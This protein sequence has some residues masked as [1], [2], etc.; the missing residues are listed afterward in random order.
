M[1]Q[2]NQ[3]VSPTSRNVT[4][5]C[6]VRLPSFIIILL[7]TLRVFAAEGPPAPVR[8][9][10]RTLP[11]RLIFAA[12]I[13]YPPFS[14]VSDGEY[15]GHDIDLIRRICRELGVS[16][17]IELA[18]WPTVI[19]TLKSGSVDVVSGILKTP[20]RARIFDFTIPYLVE[21]YAL[22]T[23]ADSG[24]FDTEDLP[25][26]SGVALREDASIET[27]FEPQGLESNL[28]LTDSLPEALRKVGR[29]TYDYT[30]APYSLGMN[31]IKE[32]SIRNI[33]VTGRPV[34]SIEYRFAVQKGDHAVL[35]ALN[36]AISSLVRTKEYDTIRSRWTIYDRY[37]VPSFS[38]PYPI[39]LKLAAGIILILLSAAGAG[40]YFIMNRGNGRQRRLPNAIRQNL[41]YREV[42]EGLTVP[43][44]WRG[45]WGIDCNRACR[46]VFGSVPREVL[47]GGEKDGEEISIT[48]Q[49]GTEQRC[50]SLYTRNDGTGSNVIGVGVDITEL[51]RRERSLQS[52][53]ESLSEKN[54]E[55]KRAM[56]SDPETGLFNRRHI[57]ERID[58]EIALYERYGDPFSI[59]IIERRS[60]NHPENRQPPT[61]PDC[62]MTDLAGEVS[63]LLRS[64]DIVARYGEDAFLIL[65]PHTSR[66]E[67]EQVSRKL[68]ARLSE[69][70]HVTDR[71]SVSVSIEYREY[72]GEGRETFL[73]TIQTRHAA[74]V[75]SGRR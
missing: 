9:D 6:R 13:E 14:F 23:N 3:G 27:F 1:Y 45:P 59:V 50:L 64:V 66:S 38:N 4:V 62:V 24:I 34:I 58:T 75:S 35:F 17:E 51:K 68:E 8:S 19:D 44:F 10:G 2:H 20:E 28:T 43:I 48:P 33:V 40:L 30:V 61:P 21:A 57:I 25:E 11:E 39:D 42:I 32:Y 67:A 54:R 70:V 15:R 53:F 47:S 31:T 63:S 49:D 29:G 60:A 71:F 55:L 56:L 36:D 41:Y 46:E 7:F 73:R 52:L 37:S 74:T 16:C 12:D 22:F 26:R 72:K 69:R 18:A 5:N 65:L